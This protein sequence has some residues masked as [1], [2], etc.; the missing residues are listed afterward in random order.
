MAKRQFFPKSIFATVEILA[1]IGIFTLYAIEF[2]GIS[3]F[4]AL[5]PEASLAQF[6]LIGLD[7]AGLE[8]SVNQGVFNVMAFTG[9]FIFLYFVFL[10]PQIMKRVK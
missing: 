6:D 10:R 3:T 9:A 2:I 1:V 7:I 8:I 5:I 4:S